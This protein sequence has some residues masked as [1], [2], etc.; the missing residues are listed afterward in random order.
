MIERIHDSDQS[1]IAKVL[2]YYRSSDESSRGYKEGELMGRA[3]WGFNP[4]LDSKELYDLQTALINMELLL[5]NTL[6]LP[7]GSR[8]LDAGCGFGKVADTLRTRFGLDVMGIDLSHKRLVIASELNK[9]RQVDMASVTGGVSLSEANYHRL[10]FPDGC[11]DGA[12]TM[13]TLVH[14]NPVEDVLAEFLRVLK[15]GGRLALF[16][17]S[18][19][20]L[21]TV[22]GIVRKYAS[23]VIERSAQYSLPRFTHEAFPG[24][25]AEAG[26]ENIEVTDISKNVYPTWR[27]LWLDAL[28]GNVYR[29]LHGSLSFPAST[30]IYLARKHLGYKVCSANKP[31]MT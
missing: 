26:F 4:D 11:F 27:H 5:G 28:K 16:E 19:P 13:E 12:F 7:Q 18:I 17:T 20:D 2:E 25:L 10:P 23:G 21:S 31:T 15:P 24:L 14:A 30:Y 8:V 29:V 6:N 22:P 9:K 3:H 1:R